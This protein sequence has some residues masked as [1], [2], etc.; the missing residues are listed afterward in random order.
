MAQQVKRFAHQDEWP[1]FNLSIQW[2]KERTYPQ[3]L[4]SN[5]YT[6]MYMCMHVCANNKVNKTHIYGRIVN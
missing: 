6:Y 3:K 2:L 5:M 4:S 1:E